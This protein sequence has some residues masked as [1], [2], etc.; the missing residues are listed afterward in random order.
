MSAGFGGWGLMLPWLLTA[1]IAVLGYWLGSELVINSGFRY[2]CRAESMAFAERD[3]LMDHVMHVDQHV[4]YALV[5][6]AALGT[7][8]AG[9]LGYLP[10]GAGLA[11]AAGVVGLLW[12][13]FV[14]AVHQL[15]HRPMGAALGRVDRA[16][17]YGLMALLLAVALGLIG[18]GWDLP[19]WLRWK[20]ALFAGVM[21]AGVGIRLALISH[22]RT[23]ALMRR[24]G[25]SEASNRDVQRGYWRATRV[26]IG[27]WLLIGGIVVLSVLKPA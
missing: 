27:L 21:M 14:E 8:L 22:F 26:L 25:P 7:A 18:G 15:R 23:W 5:L 10:G 16:S 17:R 9:L 6:Q 12:L 13:G 4:R 11:L 1:H 20:L 19:L 3:R 2:V 24:D